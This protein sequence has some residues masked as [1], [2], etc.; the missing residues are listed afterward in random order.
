[1]SFE[2]NVCHCRD[3]IRSVI[4]GDGQNVLFCGDCG[5]GMIENP[6]DCTQHFYQDSYYGQT[7]GDEAGYADYGFTAEHALLWP[8]LMIEA[9]KPPPARV[10]DVGCA[11]G[12]LLHRLVGGYELYG[13]E[14]NSTAAAVA[15]AR[16]VEIL[17]GDIADPVIAEGRIGRFDAITS[18]ATFEHVL[19]LSGAFSICLDLLRPDGAILFELPLVSPDE[20]QRAWLDSSYEHIYYPTESGIRRLLEMAPSLHYCLFEAKING[21]DP[22]IIGMATRDIATYGR[23]QRLVTAMTQDGLDGLDIAETQLNLAFH[24]VHSF[25]ATPERILALPTLFEV[26]F[27]PNLLKR[28]TQLWYSDAVLAKECRDAKAEASAR[29]AAEAEAAALPFAKL[30][31]GIT[32]ARRILGGIKRRLVG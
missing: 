20:N 31:K 27:A 8:R 26:A 1:M 29:A 30:T 32:R 5:L 14:A 18:I 11:D 2:C 15:K 16:G 17:T 3:T 22:T 6:P 21:F 19:D 24:V 7:Q 10:L 23:M 25:N 9:L 12:F 4:R 28:L 13:I